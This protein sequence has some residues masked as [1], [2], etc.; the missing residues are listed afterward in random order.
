MRS[1][2]ALQLATYLWQRTRT[3][4]GLPTRSIRLLLLFAVLGLPTLAAT[5]AKHLPLP[6]SATIQI[7]KRS[8]VSDSFSDAEMC[9]TYTVT[10]REVRRYFRTYRLINEREKHYLYQ[11]PGCFIEGTVT[12]HGKTFTWIVSPGGT[13]GTTYP[14]GVQK[15]LGT[16]DPAMLDIP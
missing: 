5:P 11:D 14:D 3:L 9:K 4:A 15:E 8:L 1:G 7:G 6:T 12:V 10:S 16:T 2:K 13:L